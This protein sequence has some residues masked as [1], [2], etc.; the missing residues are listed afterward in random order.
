VL[1]RETS[2][3]N[4]DIIAVVTDCNNVDLYRHGMLYIRIGLFNDR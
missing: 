4:S 1:K 2:S 3:V